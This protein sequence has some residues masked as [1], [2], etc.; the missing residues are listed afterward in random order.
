MVVGLASFVLSGRVPKTPCL[1]LIQFTNPRFFLPSKSYIPFQRGSGANS[2]TRYIH[3]Q[4]LRIL[5]CGADELSITSLEALYKESRESPSNVASIDVVCRPG[6]RTGRG[7]TQIRHRTLSQSKLPPVLTT[8][9]SDKG[10]RREVRTS[11]P[12]NKHIYW[13]EGE[14]TGSS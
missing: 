8:S 4:P 5:F 14:P 6:K 3:D 9:S 12:S 1:R 10:R 13:V 2:S 11:R 7:L